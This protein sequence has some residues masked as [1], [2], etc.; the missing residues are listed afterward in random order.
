[1]PGL[2]TIITMSITASIA[3]MGFVP[4]IAS[5]PQILVQL[6]STYYPV[7][8]NLRPENP[9]FNERANVEFDVYFDKHRDCPLD[10]VTQSSKQAFVL[11]VRKQDGSTQPIVKKRVDTGVG[12]I[13]YP[14]CTNCY[15]GT[16]E[17]IIR[18]LKSTPVNFFFVTDHKCEG[19]FWSVTK[20]QPEY[21]IPQ[22]ILSE[23]IN[24]RANRTTESLY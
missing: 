21:T 19:S 9:K 6:E 17:A 14:I 16:W 8:T 7:V 24:E 15:G 12:L 2:N 4:V 20:K 11:Y 3:V 18:D 22:F 5:L 13:Q 10:T 23:I 1:M